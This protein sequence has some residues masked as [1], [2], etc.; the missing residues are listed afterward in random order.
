MLSGVEYRRIDDA[1]LHIAYRQCAFTVYP[2]LTASISDAARALHL[3]V[4]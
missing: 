4:A 2:S 3:P 1:G